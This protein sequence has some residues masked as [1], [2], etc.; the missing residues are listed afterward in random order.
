MMAVISAN[1]EWAGP[2]IGAL[3]F[4]ESMAFLSLLVP[5]TAMIVASGALIG[6]GALDAWLVLP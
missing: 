6:S 3:A 4:A 5:F 1:R 2:L